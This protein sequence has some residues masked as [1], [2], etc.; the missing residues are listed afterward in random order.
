MRPI[1]VFVCFVLEMAV[2][3]NQPVCHQQQQN[4]TQS[5]KITFLMHSDA[6]CNLHQVVLTMSM[7]LNALES[8]VNDHLSRCTSHGWM[9]V[10]RYIFTKV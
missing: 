10:L 8:F 6:H 2:W 4:Y 5:L 1:V 9:S 7:C 3:E